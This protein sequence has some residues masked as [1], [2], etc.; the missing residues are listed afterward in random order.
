VLEEKVYR[1][2]EEK[3][4]LVHDIV[5][6]E[7]LVML[8]EKKIQLAKETAEALNPNIGAAE[9]RALSKEIQR[10]KAQLVQMR[11]QQEIL[12]LELERAVG[13]RESVAVRYTSIRNFLIFSRSRDLEKKTAT[14]KNI[15][16]KKSTEL[17][18]KLK[19]AK[20]ELE[21]A[22]NYILYVFFSILFFLNFCTYQ[23]HE[24]SKSTIRE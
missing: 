19:A 15:E 9:T 22:K 17:A 2:Q 7:R 18:R 12:I 24:S 21:D 1:I 23:I 10:L 4:N 20:Q 3:E 6:S 8:W 11:K 5:E 13:R 14:A 16:Q